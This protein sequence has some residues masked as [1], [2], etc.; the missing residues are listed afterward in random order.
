MIDPLLS[1]WVDKIGV[2]E[3][4]SNGKIKVLPTLHHSNTPILHYFM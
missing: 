2:M 3:W 4:W 1:R